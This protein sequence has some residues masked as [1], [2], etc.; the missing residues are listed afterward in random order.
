MT[1]RRGRTFLEGVGFAIALFVFAYVMYDRPPEAGAEG[2]KPDRRGPFASCA[3]AR[4]A[5]MERIPRGH[6]AYAE[7]LDA[8]GDGLACEPYFGR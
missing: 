3:E 5:G 7:S 1:G 2:D 4:K 8:D 6:P